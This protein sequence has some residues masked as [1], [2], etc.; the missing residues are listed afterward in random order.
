M[1]LLPGVQRITTSSAQIGSGTKRVRLFSVSLVSG[2]SAASTLILRNGTTASDTAYD[3]IDGIVGQSV[4]KNYAGGLSFPLTGNNV[5]GLFANVD[6]NISY[7]TF[8][9]TEEL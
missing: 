8:V 6:A 9:F 5:G 3:Q 1:N 7:A 4:T 2:A